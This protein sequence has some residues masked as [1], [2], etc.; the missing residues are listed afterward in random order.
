MAPVEYWSAAGLTLRKFV[1]C[2]GAMKPEVPQICPVR[3]NPL[4]GDVRYIRANPKSASLTRGRLPVR[5]TSTFVGLMSR[6][7]KTFEPSRAARIIG[8]LA[9]ALHA[10]H[11]QGIVHRDVKPANI[12]M[13]DEDRPHLTDFGLARLA[14]GT[15]KLTQVNAIVG[16]PAYLAPEQARGQ[17]DKA[18]A[19]S[20]QY[21]LGVSLYELLGGHVPFAGPIEVVIFHTL[22]TP[23]PSLRDEHSE[24]PTE[25][26]A[27]CLKALSK[28]PE[29]RYASCRELAQD[30]GRWL[31]G[32]PT[33]LNIPTQSAASSLTLTEP[34]NAPATTAGG[35]SGLSTTIRD[36]RGLDEAPVAQTAKTRVSTA[37]RILSRPSIIAATVAAILIPPL[38]VVV[39]LSTIRGKAKIERDDAPA[40]IPLAKEPQTPI[41]AVT[42]STRSSE[43]STS[44]SA[45]ASGQPASPIATAASTPP[46][47]ANGSVP[48]AVPK[49]EAPRDP[50]SSETDRGLETASASTPEERELARRLT[51]DDRIADVQRFLAAK[52]VAQASRALASC[53][54]DLRG[55][56]WDYCQ[57]VCSLNANRVV[58]PGA[59]A[60]NG[61]PAFVSEGVVRIN[62]PGDLL[63]NVAWSPR[64][65][66]V[67]TT[68][69]RSGGLLK[70]WD[71]LT[72][73][74]LNQVKVCSDPTWAL[75]YSPDGKRIA[76]GSVDA[77]VRIWDATDLRQIGVRHVHVIRRAHTN[78]Y[79][80]RVS[81]GGIQSVAFSP[82][83]RLIASA[84]DDGTVRIWD[85]D[86]ETEARRDRSLDS[87]GAAGLTGPATQNAYAQVKTCQ[88]NAG[89]VRVLFPEQSPVVCDIVWDR[90]GRW[91]ASGGVSKISFWDLKR[92]RVIST[93][94]FLPRCLALSLDG[95]RI[96]AASIDP[97]PTINVW[98]VE[99]RQ[100][101]LTLKGKK[102]V[103]YVD[104]SPDGKR[105]VTVGRW[106]VQI[107][108]ATTGRQLLELDEPRED[109]PKDK[110]FSMGI[111]FSPDG[112]RIAS[113][114][115]DLLRIWSAQASASN[116]F[117]ETGAASTQVVKS[118]SSAKTKSAAV[119]TAK[120]P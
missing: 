83:G 95:R 60:G 68:N 51:Y 12:L 1:I 40:P 87:R 105:L 22:N 18:D 19:A 38:G 57:R 24:I 106:N 27:I 75:A 20:D 39:F 94:D 86:D 90:G 63:T 115:G 52:D 74:L 78:Q 62:Q 43:E 119:P 102:D 77:T 100:I 8:A 10:A 48:S 7:T 67:A 110:V 54:V 44:R 120:R 41:T 99:T 16:T 34:P 4:N 89:K 84:G 3:V 13:D 46:V 55:W 96:A 108:D 32:R 92:E 114:R 64:G 111:R 37:R 103:T 65:T 91:L 15:A 71:A 118:S 88:F 50:I 117:T 101:D 33:T 29:E 21:S 30:L 116:P 66:R 11:Q 36:G 59:V 26:E 47:V 35:S 56:E 69:G 61:S 53:P 82:D 97:D 109:D 73:T 112:R 17:S 104:F 76:T 107:W 70:L 113:V 45:S 28:K 23:P 72:G 25:L 6:C 42:G 98:N 79:H 49:A 14:D 85:T 93:I 5:A 81:G 80:Y 31:A 2:S 58:T 9:D